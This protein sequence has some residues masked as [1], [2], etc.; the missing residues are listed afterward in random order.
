MNYLASPKFNAQTMCAALCIQHKV[1]EVLDSYVKGNLNL[2]TP[3]MIVLN[4]LILYNIYYLNKVT[5]F[6]KIKNLK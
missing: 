1:N 4:I 3:E 2:E 6:K 5:N